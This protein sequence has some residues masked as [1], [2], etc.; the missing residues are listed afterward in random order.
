MPYI[1]YLDHPKVFSVNLIQPYLKEI[2]K[3]TKHPYLVKTITNFYD[4]DWSN[5]IPEFKK[6]I[7]K[8]DK[9][10]NQDFEKTFPELIK[11]IDGKK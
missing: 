10:R 7:Y 11:Y 8:Y 5:L 6:T 4:K 2:I 1:N 9:Q 3:S